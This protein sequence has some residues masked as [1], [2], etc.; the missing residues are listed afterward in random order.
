MLLGGKELASYIKQRHLEQVRALPRPPKLAIVMSIAA[1]AATRVYVRSS[2]SRYGEDIG[3]L[4][5]VHE[6]DG[7]SASVKRLI[8][9]LN[10]DSAVT[11]I[12]VQLPFP[13]VD[14]DEVIRSVAPSKDVD[15]LHPDSE[16]E[17][18]TPKAIFWLLSS[19]GISWKDKTV[20]VVGQG[21][22]VGLPLSNML[23]AS[24][25]AKVI[26]C[27]ISTKNLSQT[28]QSCDIVISAVGKPNLI[29]TEMISP[30]CVVVDAGTA[31]IDGNLVGD[32][33]HYL[34]GR[35]GIKITPNPGGVGPMTVAALFDNLLIAA[36]K[37]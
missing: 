26:R 15:G 12:I 36:L 35:E 1:D 32:V 16:Y 25:A 8:S 19:Y 7:D 33:D 6:I 27:D 20:G 31:E 24:K 17:P 13:G 9:K 5:D 37:Q 4:I 30:G 14:T 18:A 28:L 2:K 21:R 23:E 3:A 29:T 10:H 22:L 34:Y 11:G